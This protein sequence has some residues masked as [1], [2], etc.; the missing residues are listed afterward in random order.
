M[1]TPVCFPW[2]VQPGFLYNPESQLQWARGAIIHSGPGALTTISNHENAPTRLVYRSNIML[3]YTDE[4]PQFDN[5]LK[6]L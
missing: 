2:L 6:I 1:L 4:L 5:Y 3:R